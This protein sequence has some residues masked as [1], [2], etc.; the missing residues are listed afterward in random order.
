MSTLLP[1]LFLLCRNEFIADI[2]SQAI[3]TGIGFPFI[4]LKPTGL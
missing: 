4:F 3:V 2:F 1:A